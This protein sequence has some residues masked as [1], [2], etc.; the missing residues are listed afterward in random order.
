ME[1]TL[2]CQVEVNLPTDRVHQR[3]TFGA[4]DI[5][6]L[7]MIA[8]P[9]L[10]QLQADDQGSGSIAGQSLINFRN[11]S[12]PPVAMSLSCLWLSNAFAR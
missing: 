9:K 3:Y 5:T 6:H 7:Q 11:F 12:P 10:E 2:A 8:R 1:A 4:L